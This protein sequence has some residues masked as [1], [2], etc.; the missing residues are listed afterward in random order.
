MNNLTLTL[1]S[2]VVFLTIIQIHNLRDVGVNGLVQQQDI[3]TVRVERK[4][5]IIQQLKDD[6]VIKIVTLQCLAIRQWIVDNLKAR[7]L[8]ITPLTE[9]FWMW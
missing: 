7:S 2:L 1:Y 6:F 4:H 9:G 5:L 3:V 8:S